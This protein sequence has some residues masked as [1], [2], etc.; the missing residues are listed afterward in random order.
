MINRVCI[1]FFTATFSPP[2]LPGWVV[3]IGAPLYCDAEALAAD[4]RPGYAVCI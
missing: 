4:R 3:I 2:S 1:I